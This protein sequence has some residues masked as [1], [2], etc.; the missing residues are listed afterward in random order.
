MLICLSLCLIALVSLTIPL[1]NNRQQGVL[2]RF[3]TTPAPRSW[4]LAAQVMTNPA[5][6]S[7]ASPSR[8]AGS[9]PP[10]RPPCTSGWCRTQG[11]QGLATAPQAWAA[12][13]ISRLNTALRTATPA[14]PG[15]G[16]NS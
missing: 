7:P 11:T 14:S 6:P 13:V 15:T 9:R 1:V 10:H 2:R 5:A 12:H 4:L 8:P 16:N 3:S